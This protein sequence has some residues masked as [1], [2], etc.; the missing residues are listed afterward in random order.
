[1]EIFYL[2]IYIKIKNELDSEVQMLEINIFREKFD[3][4]RSISFPGFYV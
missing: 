1:M 4:S 3:K 2:T